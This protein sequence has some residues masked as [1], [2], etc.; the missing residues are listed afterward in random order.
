MDARARPGVSARGVSASDVVFV[1]RS[2]ELA[3]TRVGEGRS[4]QRGGRGSPGSPCSKTMSGDSE[5]AHLPEES[6]TEEKVRL[7]VPVT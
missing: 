6:P 2:R 5:D 7:T 3:W 1:V 4:W